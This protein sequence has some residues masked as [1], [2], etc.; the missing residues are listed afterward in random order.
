MAGIPLWPMKFEQK[1]V[2]KSCESKKIMMPKEMLKLIMLARQASATKQVLLRFTDNQL[3]NTVCSRENSSFQHTHFSGDYRRKRPCSNIKSKL[4]RH[5][6]SSA[7]QILG[8]FLYTVTKLC[9]QQTRVSH[10]S[11]RRNRRI[12]LG[13]AA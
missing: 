5:R 8:C 12:R 6:Y 7:K 9:P 3:N 2:N 10:R 13:A 4:A 1:Y 11:Y